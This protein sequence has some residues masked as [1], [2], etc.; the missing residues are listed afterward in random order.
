MDRNSFNE[1]RRLLS[2]DALDILDSPPEPRFDQ[3]TAL[4]AAAFGAPIALVTFVDAQRQ[5]FKSHFGFDTDETPRS[6]AFCSHAIEADDTMVVPDARLD[7]RFR[8]NPLV[9][10]PPNI[11]FYAG[12]PIKSIA[13]YPVG[14]L[15]IIDTQP[16]LF[17]D[18]QRQMLRSLARMVE[19]ELNEKAV[20]AARDQAESSLVELNAQLEARIAQRVVELEEKNDALSREIAHRL[21]ME[22]TLRCSEERLRSSEERLRT[23]TDN[24][25]VLISYLDSDL[26]YQ[27]AN[28]MYKEWLGVRSEDMIG[29]SITQVLGD[30]FFE[31]RKPSLERALG[32]A[33]SNVELK[34]SRK[35]HDRILST[36]YIPHHQD[37]NVVGIYVLAT[38]ATA[39][40]Q[41]ERQLLA[42]ANA[43]P[44]TGLPNR[45]MYEFNLAKALATNRRQK[46]GLALMYLDLDDFK[47]INDNFGHA[48]GDNVL[49]EFGK[50]IKPLLR[51]TDMLARLAGD[52]FTI[53]L[54]AVTTPESCELVA[55]KILAALAQPFTVSSRPLLVSAS[56]GIVFAGEQSSFQSLSQQ[57]D[58]ALYSAKRSGKN[59]F[60][61]VSEATQAAQAAPCVEMLQQ[62]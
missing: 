7:T 51:E 53:T 59:R 29:R 8:D 37:G 38:D 44:L 2:L 26:H 36:T 55:Q 22:T 43:D 58:L 24:V 30:S 10:G 46:T 5:W 52:E 6:M 20:I 25:P 23:I 3:F 61:L 54:E 4:A 12:H 11:R 32:G 1:E 40:R 19:T 21:D 33:M 42:L 56:I 47:Q 16:R 34:V 49:V 62:R 35:G 45:R 60:S 13:G 28:A 17:S 41:H 31:E 14:T 48:A 27:F 39:S 9:V 50:R 15:C 18:N 57:A